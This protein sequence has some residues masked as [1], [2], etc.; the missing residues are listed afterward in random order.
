M[1]KRTRAIRIR[2]LRADDAHGLGDLLEELRLFDVFTGPQVGEGK[3]SLAFCLRLRAS[4]RT[5]TA[6]DAAAVREAAVAEAGRRT[7]AVLRGA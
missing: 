4:D 3:K 2:Q 7:G 1:A 6:A 5:L